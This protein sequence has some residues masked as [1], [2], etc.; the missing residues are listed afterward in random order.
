ML[1]DL[2]EARPSVILLMDPTVDFAKEVRQHFP[3]AFI[4]GRIY[5]ASQP[6][7]NPAAR[8]TAFADQVAV[9]A[10]PL[11]GIVDAWMSYNEVA[12]GDDPANLTAYNTFQVAFANQLQ[13][14]Y[15]IPAVA[16]NDGP[17][18]VP[19][20]LYPKYFAQAI[21]VSRYFGV[22]AYP[23]NGATTLR[24][25]QVANQI[26]YYRQIHQALVAAGVKSGPFIITEVGLYNGFRGVTSDT[27]M[28]QDFTWYADQLNQD[29]YVLG[30]TVFGLF[31][32]SRWA[33]FNIAGTD[34]PRIMGDYN[35]VQ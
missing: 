2:D 13:D 20:D 23:D 29:P 22:H 5:A 35:T 15:G 34:I 17:R 7:D 16:G 25:P 14:H 26:F 12:N 21:S 27:S 31:T 6:L 8:G 10:V 3:K 24:N 11:K 4:I 32:G 33:P 1:T 28:A 18:S 30:M 9:T 19:A